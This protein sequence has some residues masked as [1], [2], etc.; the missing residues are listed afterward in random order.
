M[1]SDTEKIE[2]IKYKNMFLSNNN[3]SHINSDIAGIDKFWKVSAKRAKRN[4]GVN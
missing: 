2:S 3:T 1:T 4:L